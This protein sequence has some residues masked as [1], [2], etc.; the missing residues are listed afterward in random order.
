MSNSLSGSVQDSLSTSVDVYSTN[1]FSP[2]NNVDATVQVASV[3]I[4]SAS[5]VIENV[6]ITV[7]QVQVQT[8]NLTDITANSLHVGNLLVS[9]T[10]WFQALEVDG[11]TTLRANVTC[12]N[13]ASNSTVSA[14]VVS[15][16]SVLATSVTTEGLT[17]DA[18]TVAG[19]LVCGTVS[20]TDV[21]CTG[22]VTAGIIDALTCGGDEIIGITLGLTG[23]ATVAAVVASGGISSS[24][25]TTGAVTCSSLT[26]PTTLSLSGSLSSGSLSTGTV[27][28][29]GAL[30]AASGTF[31]G[32]LS[33]SS[34]TGS[35]STAAQTGIRQIGSLQANLILND[36]AVLMRSDGNHG[37]R[38]S[39]TGA[40]LPTF[41]STN[42]NGPILWG[43]DKVGLGS[44]NL[45]VEKIALTTD[46]QNNTRL[47]GN[48]TCDSWIFQSAGNAV[49]KD[50][51]CDSLRTSGSLTAASLTTS[52][53]VTAASIV[54]PCATAA[55]PNITSLGTLS[56]LTV[57]G[58]SSLGSITRTAYASGEVIKTAI[59]GYGT[60]LTQTASSVSNSATECYTFSFTRLRTDSRVYVQVNFRY[61]IANYGADS[62]YARLSC[63][64]LLPYTTI[65]GETRA[66]FENSGGGGGRGNSLSPLTG[67][68]ASS[69]TSSAT[70]AFSVTMGR[71][72]ADDNITLSLNTNEYDYSVFIQEIMP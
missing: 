6:P 33:C 13:I 7:E 51:H 19:S 32:A 29:S 41:A 22:T 50:L 8:L 71:D 37:L 46:N 44:R 64:T 27:T 59:L 70:L 60:G 18:A 15:A 23:T 9:D 10:L 45:A 16:P 53:S 3:D 49:L 63:A 5:V 61:R 39:A 43:N 25:L 42:L 69:K 31:S 72:T 58:T 52:G 24:S 65:C 48:L 28:A 68:L 11:P 55:Q 1:T 17:S 30:S 26:G 4:A 67:W 12:A 54:G 40:T 20:T 21:A 36:W 14:L 38:V 47:Y 35:I 62:F 2:T 57:S 34:L 66:Y 56:A